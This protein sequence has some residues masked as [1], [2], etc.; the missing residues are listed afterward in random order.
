[1][2]EREMGIYRESNISFPSTFHLVAL[3]RLGLEQLFI[4]HLK[5]LS[6]TIKID[7]TQLQVEKMHVLHKKSFFT[8]FSS[9]FP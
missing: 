4:T 1:M 9:A 3:L 8:P 7:V 2:R 6:R 5:A